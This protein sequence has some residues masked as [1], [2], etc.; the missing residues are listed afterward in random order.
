MRWRN[1]A[2]SIGVRIAEYL[3]V[4]VVVGK[5][6]R[7][8]AIGNGARAAEY[9]RTSF[10]V[11]LVV[12]GLI[13]AGS[14]LSGFVITNALLQSRASSELPQAP[15]PAKASWVTD[16]E[17]EQQKKLGHPLLAL[18]PVEL[19]SIYERNGSDAVETYRD[20][21]VKINYPVASLGKQTFGK[22][23]YDVVKAT[24]HFQSAF[25]GEIVAY[26]NEQQWDAQ[27]SRHLP[28]DQ[29]VAFCQFKGIQS[30]AVLKNIDRLWF[31]G[32]GCE[33]PQL[34]PTIAVTPGRSRPGSNS[35]TLADVNAP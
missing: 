10:R 7:G 19:L 30:E 9:L 1:A 29:I 26:F 21:W 20:Q 28:K 8:I 24:A 35:T 11:P 13:A 33:L 34:A 14:S 15:P 31:Y 27:L 12:V 22:T 4:S 18:S 3:Q 23:T 16:D 6:W 25:P 32:M 2:N 5:R 17:I